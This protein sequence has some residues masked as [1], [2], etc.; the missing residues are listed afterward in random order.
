M[1]HE[2]RRNSPSVADSSPM[3]SCILTTSLMAS[4]SIDRNCSAVMRPAWKSARARRTEAGRSRL[5][6]WSAWNGGTARTVSTWLGSAPMDRDIDDLEVR[7]TIDRLAL[8]DL[9]AA[10]ADVINRRAF[11]ELPELFLPD[12]NVVID[13][14]RGD[15]IVG[16]G[17]EGIGSFVASA[18]ARYDFFQFVILS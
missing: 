17:G 10:H 8:Q 5:P 11:A 2:A 4:S 12:C 3:S 1:C 14:G 6:T 9:H 7:R 16:V 13:A 15:P 18:I